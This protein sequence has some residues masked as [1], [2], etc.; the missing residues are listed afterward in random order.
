MIPYCPT[1]FSNSCLVRA[2]ILARNDFP[3]SGCGEAAVADGDEEAA[4]ADGDEEAAVTDD[5]GEVV[6]A[7][8]GEEVAVAVAGA[9]NADANSGLRDIHLHG[10]CPVLDAPVLLTLLPD[11]STQA[12][13]SA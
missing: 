10:V 3:F 9:V 13:S 11:S 12:C 6:V 4:V 5:G 7:G 1:C 2:S 8:S